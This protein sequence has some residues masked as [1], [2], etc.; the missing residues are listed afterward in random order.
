MNFITLAFGRY[1]IIYKHNFY[2]KNVKVLNKEGV[3]Y[4]SLKK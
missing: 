1:S 4:L 2:F 3:I